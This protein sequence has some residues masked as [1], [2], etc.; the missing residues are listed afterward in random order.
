MLQSLRRFPIVYLISILLSLL[1]AGCAHAP[2]SALATLQSTPPAAGMAE[3][4]IFYPSPLVG[5]GDTIQMKLGNEQSCDLKGNTYAIRQVV[6]GNAS[7]AFSFCG[8]PNI[9]LVTVKTVGNAKYYLRVVPYDSSFLGMAS[10][11]PTDVVADG[12]PPHAGPFFVELVDEPAA[13]EMLKDLKPEAAAS[14]P[15]H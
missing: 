12:A 5:K 9:S 11:Y 10:G 1:L 14:R 6:P 8:N 2:D 3:L 13:L 15:I 7:L 4:I